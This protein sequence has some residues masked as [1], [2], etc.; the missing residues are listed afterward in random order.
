MRLID[1]AWSTTEPRSLKSIQPPH[2]VQRVVIRRVSLRRAPFIEI[3]TESA[4]RSRRTKRERRRSGR[5][6]NNEL[7]DYLA[8]L[9]AVAAV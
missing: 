7:Q 5:W 3:L 6:T 2:A 9:G 1:A 4:A 8:F